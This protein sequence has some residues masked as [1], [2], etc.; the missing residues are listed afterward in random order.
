MPTFL[1]K[2]LIHPQMLFF[3]QEE[4]YHLFEWYQLKSIW[5]LFWQSFQR[6]CLTLDYIVSS[7]QGF[8]VTFPILSLNFWPA[9]LH[10]FFFCYQAFSPFHMW[11]SVRNGFAVT[12]SVCLYPAMLESRK[13]QLRRQVKYNFSLFTHFP[14]SACLAL[15]LLMELTFLYNWLSRTSSQITREQLTAVG[16]ALEIADKQTAWLLVSSWAIR[17]EQPQNLHRK[18]KMFLMSL[19]PWN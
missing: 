5:N 19:F 6:P 3:L 13:W 7:W 1:N 18:L 4:E 11:V 9:S 2:E 14:L 12:P 8:S 16:T 15:G 17:K 10:S